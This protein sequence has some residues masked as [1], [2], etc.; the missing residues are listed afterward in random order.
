M[1]IMNIKTANCSLYSGFVWTLILT[2]IVLLSKR[3]K[4][5]IVHYDG[6][7]NVSNIS[8]SSELISIPGRL[9]LLWTST[10]DRVL[11]KYNLPLNNYHRY[12]L[13]FNVNNN[14]SQFFLFILLAG[15]I[16]TNPGPSKPVKCVSLNARSL[17]SLHNTDGKVISN[18]HCFQDLVYAHE[19]D[20]ICH[21]RLKQ[22]LRMAGFGGNLIQWFDSY[23]TNRQQR[24]TVLG[25]TSATLPVTSGV[26]QGSILGP[27]LFAL[28]VNDLPDAVKFSQ[29]AMFADDTKL[30]STIKTKNDCEHL[31]ND[32]DNLRVWSSESGLSFNDK[33]CKAQHI[34]RKF[35][36]LTT[37]YKLSS[38]LEQ[39]NSERDLGVWVQNNLT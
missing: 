28:Y 33:K 38:N 23:L 6:N 15:D 24:V 19:L 30:F 2:V 10:R 27:V 29:V 31:Q 25:A 18:I 16:A 17:K 9:G 3:S 39:I 26:P 4:P 22:K 5:E 7:A 8:I 32:L 36:P 1:N 20:I 35:T 21:S 13:Q 34:T 14:Y 11:R 37:T 12:G